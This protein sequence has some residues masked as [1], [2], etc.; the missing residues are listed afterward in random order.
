MM[1]MRVFSLVTVAVLGAR[2][3]EVLDAG[4]CLLSYRGELLGATDLCI[5]MAAFAKC[6][7]KVAPGDKNAATASAEL[8]EAQVRTQGCNLKVTPSMTIV[9][10]EVSGHFQERSKVCH[11]WAFRRVARAPLPIFC[12]VPPVH[13]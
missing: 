11:A 1:Y 5:P 4:E 6:L 10:R 7:S 12:D 3:E 13:K 8:Q 9:D 2:A